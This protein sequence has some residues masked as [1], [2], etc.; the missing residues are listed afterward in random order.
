MCFDLAPVSPWTQKAHISGFPRA[1]ALRKD[2]PCHRESPSFACSVVLVSMDLRI[3][4]V[5]D[6]SS[7]SMAQRSQAFESRSFLPSLLPHMSKMDEGSAYKNF[8]ALYFSFPLTTPPLLLSASAMAA[9]YACATT[10]VLSMIIDMLTTEIQRQLRR[11][12]Q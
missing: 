1:A 8:Q 7:R 11:R 4:D 3:L 12:H 10:G 6:R 5:Q 9:I 2:L